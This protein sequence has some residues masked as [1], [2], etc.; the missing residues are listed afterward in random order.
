MIGES[1]GLTCEDM[2]PYEVAEI[3]GYKS[4]DYFGDIENAFGSLLY[5]DGKEV[6]LLKNNNNYFRFNDKN[7]ATFVNQYY[8]IKIVYPLRKKV[9]T[10]SDLKPGQYAKVISSE[11]P[12]N[13]YQKEWYG[14]IVKCQN[15]NKV[16][17]IDGINKMQINCI[18]TNFANDIYY[19]EIINEYKEKK[20]QK[21][22]LE[23]VLKLKSGDKFY[24]NYDS[25]KTSV[26]CY[27][28]RLTT[29]FCGMSPSNNPQKLIIEFNTNSSIKNNNHLTDCGV[30]PYSTN[31]YVTDKNGYNKY[32]YLT[33]EPLYA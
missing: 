29:S 26:E 3:V 18:G 10:Y 8:E 7:K 16:T 19:F 27:F 31:N 22:T 17:I 32:N 21:L 20:P 9:L 13:P 28:I 14:C 23:D 6:I 4:D 1:T 2:K 30:I 24:Y 12:N 25:Q 15:K 11:N 5:H 33:L